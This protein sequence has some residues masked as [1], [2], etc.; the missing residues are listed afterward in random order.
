VGL[1]INGLS[2]T[3]DDW[4]RR[5]VPFHVRC[6]RVL[7]TADLDD[8]VHILTSEQRSCSANFLIGQPPARAL[9][10]ETAPDRHRLLSWDGGW[11]AH[12]NHFLDPGAL[13]VAELP[14]EARGGSEPLNS[15]HRLARFRQLISGRRLV[16]V[17]DLESFLR[18]HAGHPYS[19]CRHPDPEISPSERCATV[20]S[21]IL[22]LSGKTMRI[23]D[24]PPCENEYE[25]IRLW[26]RDHTR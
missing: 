7:R 23:T 10:V 8:A 21:I 14:P 13:G 20:T 5:Q 16:S 24:G 17:P 25:E 18:D 19:I 6:H 22:D 9:D 3:A 26:S 4:S 2:S 1:L 11:L 12:T 15:Q